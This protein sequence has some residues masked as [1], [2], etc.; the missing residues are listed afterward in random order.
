MEGAEH[1]V[2]IELVAERGPSCA[3]PEV[4]SGEPFVLAE[5][6]ADWE[7]QAHPDEAESKLAGGGL[8]ILDLDGDGLLDVYLPQ[9]GP[10]QL[11]LHAADGTLEDHAGIW[12]S[13]SQ[14]CC[15]VAR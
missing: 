8:T 6:G 14:T 12:I 15:E 11:Y 3:D 2:A 1:T 10:D 7:A 13:L 4:R 9:D 5:L